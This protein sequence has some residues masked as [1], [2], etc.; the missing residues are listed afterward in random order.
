MARV[1]R[2]LRND[3]ATGFGGSMCAIADPIHAL[4]VN[5]GPDFKKK[6][7]DLQRIAHAIAVNLDGSDG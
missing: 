4:S 2:R 5:V 6:P 7:V 1:N 3:H